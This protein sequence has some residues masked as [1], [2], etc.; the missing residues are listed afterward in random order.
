MDCYL[1]KIPENMKNAVKYTVAFLSGVS[2]LAFAG[3]NP[4]DQAPTNK[5][6]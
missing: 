3:C 5:L 4:L 6:L 2:L 1:M